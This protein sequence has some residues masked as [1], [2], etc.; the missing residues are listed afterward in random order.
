MPNRSVD[1][2]AGRAAGSSLS[3][4]P[5][6]RHDMDPL[7][8]LRAVTRRY[9]ATTQPA[10]DGIDLE[11]ERGRITAIMGP[12]GC[13]TATLLNLFGALDRPTSGEITLDGVRVDRLRQVGA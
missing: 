6:W 9:E 1:R 8:S 13:G 4:T 11:I 3:P 2:G 5:P 10:L 7:I 12:S